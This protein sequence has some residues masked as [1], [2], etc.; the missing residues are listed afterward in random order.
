MKVDKEKKGE[1]LENMFSETPC[2]G[3]L[4]LWL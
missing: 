1:M 3:I 2:N 4:T